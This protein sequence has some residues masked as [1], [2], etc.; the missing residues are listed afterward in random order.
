[1]LLYCVSTVVTS[2]LLRVA[3]VDQSLSLLLL[4]SR[5]LSQH[6]FRLSFKR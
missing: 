4:W 6:F 5:D 2:L 1:M 3:I